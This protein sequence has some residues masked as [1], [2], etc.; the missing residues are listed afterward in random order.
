MT[1]SNLQS[2]PWEERPQDGSDV[3]WRY[4]ATLHPC[5]ITKINNAK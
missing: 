3:G 4:S 2:I 1:N 5:I